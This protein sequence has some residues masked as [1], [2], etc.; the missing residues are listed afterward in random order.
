M[1]IGL[2]VY[3][4]TCNVLLRP[5]LK[6]LFMVSCSIPVDVG[7]IGPVPYWMKIAAALGQV[8]LFGR[9]ITIVNSFPDRSILWRSIVYQNH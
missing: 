3:R 1:P 9:S 5:V 6:H 4:P 8:K 2:Y 7:L